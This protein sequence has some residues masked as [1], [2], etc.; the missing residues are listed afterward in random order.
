MPF[1]INNLKLVFIAIACYSS[2][3]INAQ[4]Q[5][6]TKTIDLNEII[7]KENEEIGEVERMPE[8]K[9]NVIYAGK[10]QKLFN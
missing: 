7:I 9:D 5:D 6:S 2:I 4:Q 1:N 3:K 10:K 8:M